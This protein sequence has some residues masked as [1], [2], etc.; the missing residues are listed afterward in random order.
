MVNILVSKHSNILILLALSSLK[1]SKNFFNEARYS[2]ENKQK[3]QSQI[4]NNYWVVFLSKNVWYV[5]KTS[6]IYLRIHPIILRAK[7]IEIKIK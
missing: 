4:V 1:R 7:K 5:I 3:Q 6:V 2:I